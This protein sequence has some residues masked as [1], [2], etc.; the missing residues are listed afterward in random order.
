[1]PA[2]RVGFSSEAPKKSGEAAIN[3]APR[4]LEPVV[5][6]RRAVSRG[7]EFPSLRERTEGSF[8]LRPVV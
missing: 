6:Q 3:N 4:L 1:M 2:Q 5:G 8:V 7:G